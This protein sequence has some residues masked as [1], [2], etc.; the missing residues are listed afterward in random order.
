MTLEDLHS[1][2]Q[3][4]F[5]LASERDRTLHTLPVVAGRE[6]AEKAVIALLSTLPEK[7]L[8]PTKTIDVILQD[9]VPGLAP[10]QAGPRW[11]Q[12]INLRCGGELTNN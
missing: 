3:K 10:G 1:T 5:D 11:I 12:L 2:R 6:N 7:G 4:I 9:V 8:G